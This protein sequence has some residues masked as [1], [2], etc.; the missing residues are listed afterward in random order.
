[1]NLKRNV[2][3]DMK[4][5]EE[6]KEIV[7]SCFKNYFTKTQKI[8][9]IKAKGRV[10]SKPAYARISSPNFH[11][12]AMDGIAVDAKNTFQATQIEPIELVIN[13]NA[14]WINTGNLMPDKTNAVI[15]I[16]YLNIIDENI[17]QIE[18][19]VFP[20]QNVRKTGEDIV[21]TKMLFPRGH[22]ISSYCIGALLSGA[23]FEVEVYKKPRVLIIPTG[24]ELKKWDIVNFKG[25]CLG[26]IV[27]SNSF[28]LGSLCEDYGA[29]FETYSVV[30]DDLSKIKTAVKNSEDYDMIFIIGGSSAG[31]KDLAKAVLKELGKICFHGVAMM[32]GKPVLLGKV[33]KKPVFGIPG[34]PVSAIIAFEQFAGPLL[35]KMQNLLKT[36][37]HF[38]KVFPAKKIFSK[39][40]QE[41]FI[42]VQIGFVDNKFIASLL[43]RGAGSITTLTQADGIIRIPENSE[44]ISE[45]KEFKAQLLRPLSQIKNTIVITGSHDN[46]LDLLSDEIKKEDTSLCVAS[47]HVGSMGGLM[48]IK[49]NAC[50]I[51]GSHLLDPEDGTYNLSYIKK[52]LPDQKIWTINLAIRQQGLIVLSN[53]PK[54]IQSIKD[55]KDKDIQFVNR[56]IGSGTR[57]LFDFKLKSLGISAS[58][59]KGYENEEYTHMLVAA[60]VLSGRADTGLGINAAAIALG[61]GFIPV[62]TEEYDLIIP[63]RFYNT[64]KVQALLATINSKDFQD[65]LLSLG[66][67]STQNTGKVKKLF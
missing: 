42:R 17:V 33:S 39:L 36:P 24:S 61:L 3:L 30:K 14:F 40:G 67:Y 35:L 2:Y 6:A 31:S 18:N 27:E 25:L 9:S 21:K 29:E 48:A 53:N 64:K 59:I 37:A 38:I 65:K 43:P 19:P 32:P 56:Q 60:D 8:L 44:G 49:K 1:M 11:A 62:V 66:G 13:K 4:S 10:L 63:D 15:M 55:L 57:I 51:A 12:A 28:V 52:Y 58:D 41:E 22:K 26:D 47:N 54:N 34:Y 23:V 50:H 16:E 7:F 46:A 5:I 20:W 45:N